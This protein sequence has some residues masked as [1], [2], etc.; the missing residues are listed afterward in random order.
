MEIIFGCVI[1][2]LLM[3]IKPR[4]VYRY[5]TKSYPVKLPILGTE[6]TVNDVESYFKENNLYHLLFDAKKPVFV[7]ENIKSGLAPYTVIIFATK[8]DA[9]YF[10]LVCGEEKLIK[11]LTKIGHIPLR[12]DD[13]NWEIL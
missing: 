6:I 8:H 12:G 10:E 5:M 7:G 3:F 1:I 4:W 2:F 13:I 9:T 11:H